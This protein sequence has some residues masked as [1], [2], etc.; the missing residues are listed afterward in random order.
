MSDYESRSQSEG[1]IQVSVVV[2]GG[3]PIEFNVQAQAHTPMCGK[4]LTVWVEGE[5]EVSSLCH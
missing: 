5:P 4:P 2:F 1:Y 3:V